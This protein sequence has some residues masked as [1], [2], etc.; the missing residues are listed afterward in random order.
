[1]D[2]NRKPLLLEAETE[3]IIGAA[4][5]VMNGLGPGFTEK[6]YE[7]A[8]CV[9]F[10]ANGIHFDQQPRYPVHYKQVEVGL[11]IP[12]LVVFDSVVVDAKTIDAISDREVGQMLNYLHITGLPVGLIINFQ[13]AKLTWRRIAH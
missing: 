3:A 13:R 1:M 4:F 8:M 10:R 5:E 12:D 9:E 2:E 6:V 11:F 7:N